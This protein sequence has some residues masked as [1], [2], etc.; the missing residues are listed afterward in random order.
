MPNKHAAVKDLRKNKRRAERNIRLKTHVKALTK[1][2]SELIKA[3]KK[4]EALEL[5]RKLQQVI[6]KASKNYI[7]HSN[8]A[9]R[10]VSS[11]QR[12][13]NKLNAK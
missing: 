9:S 8:K 10:K 1:Q 4:T 5:S 7:F 12:S 13:L 6:A 2:M 11:M 3:N